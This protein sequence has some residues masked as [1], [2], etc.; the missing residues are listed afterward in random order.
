MVEDFIKS[1]KMVRCEYC[2]KKFSTVSNL[3]NHKRTALYCIQ[4]RTG[5]K[6]TKHTCEYCHRELTTKYSLK[7]HLTTC[8]A[9]QKAELEI[10]KQAIE[11]EH[12]KKISKL[13]T[14]YKL[15]ISDNKEVNK[16]LEKRIKVLDAR[17]KTLEDELKENQGIVKGMQT[18]PDKRTI[19]NTNTAYVHPKLVNL[20]INNIRALTTEF[21]EERVSDGILTYEKAAK[22]YSGMLEVICELITHENDNGEIE[23]NYVCT[24]VSRNSFHRLL[25]SKKWKADKGGR[26]L[27]DMLDR[28]INQMDE[29]KNKAYDIY[30]RTPH[31]SM[32]WSQVDWERK[33][34]SKLF[35]G[36][37]CKEG[38][39]DREDLVNALRKE[40]A[41][42]ASV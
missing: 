16:K 5:T 4:S 14:K 26:Y 40:I 7:T 36:V 8:S 13:K 2:R 39:G 33:N 25:K 42:R 37:V 34:I 18:A 35:S 1:N 30:D 12:N 17:V 22:G 24:D 15:I 9:K 21:I 19:Y 27:N 10:Y 31:D 3:N 6:E 32:E 11:E 20:P 23:R 38:T 28:F 41:K 29:Y